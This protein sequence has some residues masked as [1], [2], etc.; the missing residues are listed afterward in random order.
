MR[1]FTGRHRLAL[2]GLIAFA[3]IQ[4]LISIAGRELVRSDDARVAGIAREM[5]LSRN[6]AVPYLNGEHFLEY[7][8]LGYL[9]IAFMLSL[10]DH[11][12]HF[13]ALLP[14][15]LLGVGTVYLTF[16]IGLLLG[17]TRIGLLAGFILATTGGFYDLNRNCLVDPSLLFWITVSLYG[18]IATVKAHNRTFP[19][20]AVFYFGMAAAFLSKG[21]IG[22]A[23]PM[24]VV[25]AYIV[26][27]R[28]WKILG[29][30]RP[31]AGALVFCLPLILWGYMAFRVGG[32]EVL[33]EFLRQSVWRFSSPEA[34][35]SAPFYFYLKMVLYLHLPWTLLLFVL[36]WIR[37]GPPSCR[38][39]LLPGGEALFPAVW[40]MVTL[41]G[42]SVASAKRNIYMAPLF[43]AFAILAAQTWDRIAQKYQ[44]A[45]RIEPWL[46]PGL[47]VLFAAIHFGIFLPH[48]LPTS[49][50]PEF[51]IVARELEPKKV[52]LYKPKEALRGAAVFYLGKNVPVARNIQ[53]LRH[54]LAY[55]GRLVVVAMHKVKVPFEP[56]PMPPELE[57][58]SKRKWGRRFLVNVYLRPPQANNSKG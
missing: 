25:S 16:R 51:E 24:A 44:Q 34:P 6:F 30:L 14:A 31:I 27:S 41:L 38:E 42:L 32:Y 58:L 23:V 12:V 50:H 52:V 4:G 8:P 37:W 45:H 9:P 11:P 35:H 1:S 19:H 15:V 22:L 48:E 49:L 7:P 40:F 20:F 28:N 2:W 57:L 36:A 26:L 33:K 47:L 29:R 21:L 55:E 18:F 56:D 54:I 3:L 53:E 43:P 39:R 46:V 13:L 10:S 5:A 17:G